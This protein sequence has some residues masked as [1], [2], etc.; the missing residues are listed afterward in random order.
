MNIL[1]KIKMKFIRD[2][3]LCITLQKAHFLFDEMNYLTF[4]AILM[5]NAFLKTS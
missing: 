5:H 4:I 1:K 2:K 3:K